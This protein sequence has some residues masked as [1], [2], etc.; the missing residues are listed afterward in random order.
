MT[1]DEAYGGQASPT[2]LCTPTSN[3]PEESERLFDVSSMDEFADLCDLSGGDAGEPQTIMEV[4]DDSS[5]P[6]ESHP[7]RDKAARAS[8]GA[9]SRTR[10]KE[11]LNN[12]LPPKGRTAEEAASSN[13]PNSSYLVLTRHPETGMSLSHAYRDFDGTEPGMLERW[14][15][16]K[17]VTPDD[18]LDAES[19]DRKVKQ[20]IGRLARV[21]YDGAGAQTVD[22]LDTKRIRAVDFVS[23]Q[24]TFECEKSG[25]VEAGE[26]RTRYIA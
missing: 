19:G 14:H 3:T 11:L 21:S 22:V 7:G 20:L 2:S 1:D 15:H 9:S 18:L 17:E 8:S 10:T 5:L 12:Y 6:P 23:M 24:K 13:I 25:E 26:V 16:Y 4:A